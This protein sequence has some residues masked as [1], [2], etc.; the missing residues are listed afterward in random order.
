[1]KFSTFFFQIKSDSHKNTTLIYHHHHFV[2]FL[3]A[4][5]CWISIFHT[6]FFTKKFK[7]NFFSLFSAYNL[8]IS[9]RQDIIYYGTFTST[10]KYE[11]VIL[12]LKSSATIGLGTDFHTRE[13][14]ILRI[15]WDLLSKVEMLSQRHLSFFMVLSVKGITDDNE[16][17]GAY[18]EV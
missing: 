4:F 10:K 12:A 17:R 7:L 9:K 13:S 3:Q 16:T 15:D 5:H 1:M 11:A 2:K 8:Q 18:F 14:F 6:F